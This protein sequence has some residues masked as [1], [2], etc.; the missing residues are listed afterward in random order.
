MPRLFPRLRS[1]WPAPEAVREGFRR[2]KFTRL[3][4]DRFPRGT[5]NSHID[6]ALGPALGKAVTAYV[7]ALVRECAQRLWKESGPSF[8]A[9]IAQGFGQ[10]VQEHHR[11]V[12]KEAR[13]SS[14]LE[15]VQL[16]QLALLKL[17]FNTIDAQIAS[18]RL[19]LE[20][21]RNLPMRQ[22]T[23]QS[24][25]L[26][27]QAVILG[28]Q[29]S[30]VRFRVARESIR[31]LMRL[32][33]GGLKNL[34]KAILGRSWPVPEFMLADPILQLDGVGTPRD[35][36]R[37]YPFLLHDF[38]TLSEANRCV[39]QVLADWLPTVVDLHHQPPPASAVLPIPRQDQGLAPGFLDTERRVR[40]LCAEQELNDGAATWLDLPENAVALLGG[41]ESEWPRPG[42]WYDPRITSLQR[43]LNAQLASKLERAGLMPAV[44]A[45]H[46]L[47]VVYPALG[48]VDAETLLFGYLSGTI[49]RREFVRRLAITDGVKDANALVRRID[50]LRK[51]YRQNP[52]AG[53]RQVMA[54]FAGDFL[55]LRRDLKLAWRAYVGMDSLRLLTDER[56]AALSRANNVLQLFCREDVALDARGDV[57]GHVIV[58]VGLRGMTQLAAQMRQ[59]NLSAAAHFSRYFYDPCS[60]L[61]EQFDAHKVTVEGDGLVLL[62]LE[63]GGQGAERLAVARACCLAA[64][65]LGQADAMN[66]ENEH[67]GLPLIELGVGITYAAD[68]PTYLYD[69]F[70]KVTVSP[71]IARARELS[72]CDAT[73]RES[74]TLPGRRGLCVATPVQGQQ[75]EAGDVAPP[76]RYNV[77][78]IELDAP[79]FSQLHVE[80][81]LHRLKV[82]DKQ[83]T[84]PA[85]LFAGTCADVNG[86][87]H[88]LLVREH[89]VKLWMGRQLLDRDDDGHRY[90]EV[91]SD[92]RLVRRVGE[93]LAE[94][95]PGRHETAPGVRQLR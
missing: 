17:L 32:E 91:V 6:V 50:G 64:A 9:T 24:L 39:L 75:G 73:L 93:R 71:A 22:L 57:V 5:D 83:G 33:H 61:I 45:S 8:S 78:G 54:R 59:R 44:L 12:V 72:S 90:Y 21:A 67:L 89:A 20:D 48:L 29:A 53:K 2:P 79:A 15:R 87:S 3:R 25:Q 10:V 38:G 76:V 26:H 88:W 40:S 95:E 94:V 14:Q 68:A 80:I 41:A 63:H 66:A 60:A 23:G 27:Q 31:E 34:R 49:R 52:A 42:N 1:R 43:H 19:E 13:S 11:A 70:R 74:C 92:P 35:F 56:E 7:H 77:N 65:I 58:K 47:S 82:R 62:L 4:L 16:F 30:Y 51:E 85:V 69:Q 84:S 55:R 36:F 18:L 46:E 37:V 81:S 86:D 28:R